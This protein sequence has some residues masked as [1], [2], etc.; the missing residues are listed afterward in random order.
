MEILKI[1]LYETR[2]L[3]EQLKEYS[4][5]ANQEQIKVNYE[6]SQQNFMEFGWL[7]KN[8]DHVDIQL[9]TRINSNR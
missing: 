9:Q 6:V 2:R 4:I 8:V 1:T 3:A 7:Q 5:G